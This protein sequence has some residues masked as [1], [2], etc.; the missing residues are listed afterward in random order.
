MYLNNKEKLNNQMG[1]H[2]MMD[3]QSETDILIQAV[4]LTKKFGSKSKITAVD[5]LNLSIK[6]GETFGLLGPNGAGKTTTVRLLNCIL[7]AT[8][9]TATING[10]DLNKNSNQV[11][12]VTGLLAES[13]GIYE[14]L[15]AYEFLEFM[16]S[17]YKIKG[18]ML[19]NRILELLELMGLTQRKNHLIE[20]YSAGMKQKLLLAAALI[21]DPPILFFD[22]PTSALDP[23]ASYTIKELIKSLADTGGKTIV[24]CS[25]ILP[26]VEELCDR[27]GIMYEGK[28]VAVGT[29]EKILEQANAKTL[30]EAFITLTGGTIEKDLFSWRNGK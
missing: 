14:K 8:S 1:H 6:K 7:K 2:E 23:R 9:G 10:Y 19:H 22:E 3:E 15:S 21:N 12:G 17:L 29:I 5:N 25:H 27:I 24:I 30:E 28:L 26:L 16:G 13:P 4:N 11:K 18:K 20:G